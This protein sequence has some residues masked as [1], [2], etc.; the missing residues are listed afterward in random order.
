MLLDTG[1]D[2]TVLP[3]NVADELELNYSAS[4]YEV[5]GFEDRSSLARAVRAE[6]L[7]LGLTFRGQ[8]LLVEQDWG[9]IGR[10]VLNAVSLTFDGPRSSWGKS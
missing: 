3:Q 8:F 4:S 6:M 7:F 5:T 10:N 1:A 2:V 9:I